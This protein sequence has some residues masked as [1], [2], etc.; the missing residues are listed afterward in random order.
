M[1]K[2][3]IN[4]NRNSGQYFV[5]LGLFLIL[6]SLPIKIY[7]QH[8]SLSTLRDSLIVKKDSTIQKNTKSYPK[9]FPKNHSPKKALILG[10][11]IPGSGQIYNRKFWKLPIV[12]GGIGGLGYLAYY[13]GSKYT[14]YRRSYLAMVDDDPLT[15]NTYDPNKSQAD[16]K[17]FRDNYQKFYEY[18][19]VGLVGFYLL[20]VADAFVDAH[21]MNFDISDDLSLSIK[22]KLE[23]NSF[24]PQTDFSN[25]WSAGLG[26]NFQIGSKASLTNRSFF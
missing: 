14:G 15:V 26:L 24:K 6:F 9:A 21:L 2:V 8:D 7:A 17:L 13:N 5:V 12:Y 22:P 11:I 16:M 1:S 25:R 4:V 10:L 19:V 18:S 23:F 3:E 20:T